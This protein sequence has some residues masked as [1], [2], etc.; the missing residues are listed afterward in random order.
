VT[1]PRL[2]SLTEVAT[3]L[4]EPATEAY[5]EGLIRKGHLAGVRVANRMKVSEEALAAY[6]AAGGTPRKRRSDAAPVVAVSASP[7]PRRTRA[8]RSA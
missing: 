8:R 4:G 7:F 5:V 6:V 1:L 3:Y 2:M